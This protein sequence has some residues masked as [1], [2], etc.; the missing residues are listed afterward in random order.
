MCERRNLREQ[1]RLDVV[2]CDEQLDRLDAGHAC[3]LEQVLPFRDEEP[4]LVPPA[5][6]VQLP[7][8]LELLV[9]AGGDQ[10]R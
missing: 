7:N 2:A 10:R 4:E 6:I 5:A 1:C 3:R 9:L 8:E